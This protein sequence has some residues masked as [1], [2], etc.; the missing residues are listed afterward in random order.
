MC[1]PG[2]VWIFAG[3]LDKVDGRKVK[4]YW[5][6]LFTDILLITQVTRDRVI[7]VMEDP[8]YLINVI[9]TYFDVKKK[10][11]PKYSS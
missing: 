6:M 1:E 5:A 10:G 11:E 2:R 9:Q 7:F 8:I 4:H 3:E